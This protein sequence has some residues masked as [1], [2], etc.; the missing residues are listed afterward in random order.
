M[1][2][3]A[4]TSLTNHQADAIADAHRWDTIEGRRAAVLA[5]YQAGRKSTSSPRAEHI[6]QGLCPDETTGLASRD[7]DCPACRALGT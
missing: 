5:A 1:V 4:V 7:P 3:R 6:Y 2:K